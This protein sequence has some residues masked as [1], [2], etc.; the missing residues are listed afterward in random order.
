VWF[1]TILKSLPGFAANGIRF[2]FGNASKNYPSLQYGHTI[3]HFNS[4]TKVN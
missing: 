4:I 2:L 3:L 1:I